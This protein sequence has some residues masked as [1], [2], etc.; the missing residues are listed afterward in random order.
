MDAAPPVVL[1]LDDAGTFK[2]VEGTC[3]RRQRCRLF[4][5][6]FDRLTDAARDHRPSLLL[7]T[8]RDDADRDRVLSAC[9][10]RSLS[11][12][13]VVLVDLTGA[14]PRRAARPRT[15]LRRAPVEVLSARVGRSGEPDFAELDE[16]LNDAIRRLVPELSARKDRLAVTLV[17]RCHGA[18]MPARLRTKDVSETG[19]F[20]R[21]TRPPASGRK[22]EVSVRL[23]PRDAVSG[24]CEV[25]REVRHGAAGDWTDGDLIAGV[26]VRFVDL[27]DQA[28]EAL[29]RFVATGI[30]AGRRAPRRAAR[31]H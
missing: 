19:L 31:A 16:R 8:C 5:A 15:P 3:L 24:L 21:T 12:V 25:V 14:P 27:P 11:R 20:L 28:R 2:A 22:F 4:K 13:P 1:L 10:D 23:G 7:A 6:P 26:G 18:G 30:R 17:A 29:R 9:A